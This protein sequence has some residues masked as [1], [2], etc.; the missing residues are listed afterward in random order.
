MKKIISIILLL[1]LI[2]TIS[3]FGVS[4]PYW[5]GNPLIIE[6]GETR[7]I[8][9]NLQNMVEEDIIVKAEII[10]GEDIALLSQ[11]I[12]II[13]AKT[14]DTI[15]PLEITIPQDAFSENKT[16]KIN[17]KKISENNSGI[18]MGTGMSVYFDVITIGNKE[19]KNTFL[20]I[21]IIGI[22][23]LIIAIILIKK[24]KNKF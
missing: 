2:S 12:F 7:I 6:K 8:N 10:Q 20:I 19:N 24:K 22:I 4:S 3:A 11:D 15:I 18:V 23:L 14:Y 1:T 13:K 17:F 5:Q 21:G 16:I 9:L